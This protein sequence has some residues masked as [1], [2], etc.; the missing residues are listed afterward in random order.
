[1]SSSFASSLVTPEPIITG[2]VK[3]SVAAI[4]FRSPYGMQDI[5]QLAE[6][7]RMLLNRKA[8]THLFRNDALYSLEDLWDAVYASE[9]IR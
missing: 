8:F 7:A 5:L 9:T 4:S 2:D 3:S 6:E 1:V